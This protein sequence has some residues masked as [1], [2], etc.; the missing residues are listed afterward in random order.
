MDAKRVLLLGTVLALVDVGVPY[1]LLKDSGT[2]YSYIF[3][4]VLTAVVLSVG[5]YMVRGWGS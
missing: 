3:W 5:L 1:L 2:W 4:V